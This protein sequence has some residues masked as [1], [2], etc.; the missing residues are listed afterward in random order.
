MLGAKLIKTEYSDNNFKDDNGEQHCQQSCWDVAMNDYNRRVTDDS[1]E[2]FSRTNLPNLND[3]T[4]LTTK[5]EEKM[6]SN[7]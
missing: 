6:N 4:S 1:D 7:L 2:L 3:Q 5:L